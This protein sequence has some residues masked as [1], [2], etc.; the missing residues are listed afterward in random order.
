MSRVETRTVYNQILAGQKLVLNLGSGHKKKDGVVALDILESVHPDIVCDLEKEPIPLPDNSCKEVGIDYTLEHL[1]NT[2]EVLS[3]AWR[4]CDHGG[5]VFIGV[6][7]CTSNAAFIDPTHK[8]F[9]TFESYKY[10]DARESEVPHYDYKA[11]FN[12]E[13]VQGELEPDIVL[14]DLSKATNDQI[15]SMIMQFHHGYGYIRKLN[16]FL[17]AIKDPT[18]MHQKVIS[19]CYPIGFQAGFRTLVYK[20]EY[21]EVTT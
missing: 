19:K 13:E 16:F 10:F 7:N 17:R 21:K 8:K 20:V 1:S 18:L 4:V 5:M 9:F 14:G 2:L 6:P 15:Y 12:V 11:T 3:E